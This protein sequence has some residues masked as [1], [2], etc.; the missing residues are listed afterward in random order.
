[1]GLAQVT[2]GV[3]GREDYLDTNNVIF[4]NSGNFGSNTDTTDGDIITF[5]SVLTN[6][7]AADN[8]VP[9]R[10]VSLNSTTYPY[11][12]ARVKVATLDSGAGLQVQLYAHFTDSSTS[13]TVI[14]TAPTTAMTV[15]TSPAL[16]T[17]KTIDRIG[18]VVQSTVS[19]NGTFNVNYQVD[20]VMSF[21]ELL[22]LPTVIQPIGFR[23]QR[24]IVEIPIIQRE[25][26]QVQDL[27]SMSPEVTVAGGLVNTTSGQ[28]GWTNTYTAD[29]WWQIMLGITLETG[30][31]QA[32]GNPT[33]QWFSSDEIQGKY[34]PKAFLPQ[35]VPGRVNYHNYALQL[36]QMDVGPET[37]ANSLTGVTY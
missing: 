21:K 36:K 4:S 16:P 25:G 14:A 6:S 9:Y 12:M 35:Q 11:I 2:R 37:T 23:K 27:G 32:D 18:V 13:R 5:T 26:G 33:W 8:F 1:L 31:I 10:S 34:L 29:Q 3:G 24:N 19:Q 17:G 7:T 22:T 20:F 15:Y 30:T 28:S